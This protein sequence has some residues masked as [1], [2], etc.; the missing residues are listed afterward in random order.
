MIFYSRAKWA[1]FQPGYILP[2]S[3]L[4]TVDSFSLGG[5]VPEWNGQDIYF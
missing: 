5:D 2:S 1:S 4:F 3:D